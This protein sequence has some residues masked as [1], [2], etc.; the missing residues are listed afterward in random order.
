MGPGWWAKFWIVGEEHILELL[1]LERCQAFG[2]RIGS[3][4]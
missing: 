4:V 2:A 1:D 3:F